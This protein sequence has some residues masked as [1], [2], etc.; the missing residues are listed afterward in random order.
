MFGKRDKTEK[1]KERSSVSKT[2]LLL[3]ATGLLLFLVGV[4]RSYQL[5]DSPGTVLKDD[6]GEAGESGGS[7]ETEERAGG[8]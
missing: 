1:R 5:D 4:K 2:K 7:V 3:G 8:L 6:P